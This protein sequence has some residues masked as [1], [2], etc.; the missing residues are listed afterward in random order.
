MTLHCRFD[1]GPFQSA[2]LEPLGRKRYLA[3]L[4]AAT[5]VDSPAFYVSARGAACGL[6]TRPSEAPA[7]TF[8]VPV[9]D[10]APVF[11]D[12]FEAA[13]A[14]PSL[15]EEL[16]NEATRLRGA[17]QAGARG[18]CC[19]RGCAGCAVAHRR[20]AGSCAGGGR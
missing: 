2:A 11:A 7:E 1:G 12:D 18:S 19:C 9:A 4:P 17:A 13:G 5:R 20:S 10:F 14:D 8:S 3:V 6:V 16:V 15:T